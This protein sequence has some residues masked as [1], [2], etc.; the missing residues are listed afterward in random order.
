MAATPQA[1]L[2]LRLSKLHAVKNPRHLSRVLFFL[3]AC[4]AL[5]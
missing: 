5:Q 4:V 3:G 2:R 1:R